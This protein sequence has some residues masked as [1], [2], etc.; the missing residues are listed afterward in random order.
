MCPLVPP[1]LPQQHI[2][3]EEKALSD[4]DE[5]SSLDQEDPEPPQIGQDVGELVS[6]ICIL[7]IQ[8]CRIIKF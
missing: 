1:E 6:P 5:N 2:C 8:N 3:K 7:I 4:Q